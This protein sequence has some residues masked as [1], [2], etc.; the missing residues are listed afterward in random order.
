MEIFIN[1]LAMFAMFFGCY[2]LLHYVPLAI[3]IYCCPLCNRS[4]SRNVPIEDPLIE[5]GTS[6]IQIVYGE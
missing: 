3:Q 5:K 2:I 6:S 1:F 4:G